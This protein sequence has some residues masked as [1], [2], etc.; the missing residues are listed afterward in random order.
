MSVISI[1]YCIF[2][3][4]KKVEFI[5]FLLNSLFSC[6]CVLSK[7]LVKTNCGINGAYV[8]TYDCNIRLINH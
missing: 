8:M 6:F 5:S 1:F 4:M 7:H 2:V 3:L